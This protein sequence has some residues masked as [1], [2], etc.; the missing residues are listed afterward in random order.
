MCRYVFIGVLLA[1]GLLGCHF[2]LIEGQ[3]L[4]TY[5]QPLFHN[6]SVVLKLSGV[7]MD[8]DQPAVGASVAL[9]DGEFRVNASTMTGRD[10][11]Y[12]LSGS[13]NCEG[14][15]TRIRIK[16]TYL[17]KETVGYPACTSK[18]QVMFFRL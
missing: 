8:G 18:H 6:G 10:G 9:W 1:G 17:S 11:R 16:V 2:Q 5:Q 3:F 7:V 15:A 12:R 4:P 13:A 14:L